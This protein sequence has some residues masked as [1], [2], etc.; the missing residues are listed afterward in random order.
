MNG[1]HKGVIGTMG[2]LAGTLLVMV[3]LHPPAGETSA[4]RARYAPD[5]QTDAGAYGSPIHMIGVSLRGNPLTVAS[6]S[7]DY[8]GMAY[9][10]DKVGSGKADVPRLFLANLP[11]DLGTLSEAEARKVVFFKVVLPL[12]LYANEEILA[13]RARLWQLRYRLREGVAP[14]PIDRLWLIVKAEEYDAP[15]GNLE[16]LARRIDIIPPSLAL[17]QA[18]MESGWGTSALVRQRNA[19]FGHPPGAR[20]MPARAVTSSGLTV[21][22]AQEDWDFDN[23]LESVRAYARNLNVNPAYD[24]FRRSRAEMRGRGVPVD[25]LSLAPYLTGFSERRDA[26]V[27]SLRAIIEANGLSSLDDARLQHPPAA[28]VPTT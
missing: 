5:I 19:L 17:A 7:N 16:D 3:A 28:P 23:L 8:P 27:E 6:L 12:V 1:V 20:R 21:G 22:L 26:Y 18:A 15:P 14:G 2:V 25:G 9:D 11:T 24:Q 10:L 13:D 4:P